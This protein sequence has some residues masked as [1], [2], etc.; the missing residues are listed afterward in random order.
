MKKL[1]ANYIIENTIKTLDKFH[2]GLNEKS[3]LA[4]AKTRV[5]NDF[6]LM[7]QMARELL[8]ICSNYSGTTSR[9]DIDGI[10]LY[11]SKSI[12]RV[13]H[14]DDIQSIKNEV[15]EF[16]EMNKH[17]G[18]DLTYNNSNIRIYELLE[19]VYTE[20]DY[21]T[22]HDIS[23]IMG[24]ININRE[25]NVFSPKAFSGDNLLRIKQYTD[26]ADTYGLEKRDNYHQSAKYK[27]GRMIKGQL[28]GSTI[29]NQVFDMMQMIAP[30]SWLAKMSQTGTLIEKEE[31]Y[32]LRNTIKYLRQDGILIYTIPKTRITKD[33]A[34]L[35]SKLL[36][37][38][39]VLRKEND[40]YY[41]HIIGVKDIQSESREDVYRLLQNIDASEKTELTFTYNLPSGGIKHPDFFRGSALDEEELL[42]L[43]KHS[44]L[45]DSFWKSQEIKQE[46]DSIRPLLPF[47]MGQIGLVL[48][49]GCLD[50]T[51]EEFPGQQHA[52]KGMVTKIRNVENNRE[53]Q[54]E[55]SIETISNKVIIN[56]LTPNGD[57]IELA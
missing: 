12:H 41:V 8:I 6:K 45:I 44:G 33:M 56:L 52:I 46:D 15:Y 42:E 16:L 34:F 50:G 36:R 22:P 21:I 57:F 37:D 25:F 40:N 47:N 13:K 1:Y 18:W 53:G 23:K 17:I 26:K 28:Q 11:L 32:T 14:A 35:M 3:D 29:S 10:R 2:Q 20:H 54:N 39:Q 9:S 43:V 19:G 48:T 5:M 49:S 51:V 24:S 27:V 4:K 31:K 30:V 7:E 38:V 55:T